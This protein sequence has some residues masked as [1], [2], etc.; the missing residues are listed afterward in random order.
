VPVTTS[1]H[2]TR[3]DATD[4]GKV[5]KQYLPTSGQLQQNILSLVDVLNRRSLL[6]FEREDSASPV[7]WR[8]P[9][10]LHLLAH[11]H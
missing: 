9:I 11:L 7:C 6:W 8:R 4:V 10:T 1:A 3:A 2:S 5:V